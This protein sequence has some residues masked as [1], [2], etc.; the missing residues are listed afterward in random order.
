MD[1]LGMMPLADLKNQKITNPIM[2][3]ERL[4][5][6]EAASMVPE[7]FLL[8]REAY[9]EWK[10]SQLKSEVTKVLPMCGRE[11]TPPLYKYAQAPGGP[12]IVTQGAR[13]GNDPCD[14]A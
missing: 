9:E 13:C 2:S 1:E 12:P 6:Q 14:C 4:R 7:S 5:E 10:Q 3:L 8:D 11:N